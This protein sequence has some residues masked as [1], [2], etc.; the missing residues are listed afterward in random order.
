VNF[1]TL[2]TS[3]NTTVFRIGDGS[4]ASIMELRFSASN[5]LDLLRYLS[6]GGTNTSSGATAI[7]SN[8]WVR[9]TVSYTITNS[10]THTFKVWINGNLE[11]N[12]SGGITLTSVTSTYLT[13]GW[14]SGSG[15]ITQ[16][17]LQHIY[18]DD[19]TTLDDPGDIR[20]T[21]KKPAALN[22]NN[23]DTL[24]GSAT[25]RWDYVSDIPVSDS[26]GIQHA[27]S[28]DVQ[29]NFTL[30][31]ASQGDANLNGATIV[32]R[33]AW[34][35]AKRD[36][37][38]TDTPVSATN[39]GKA[40]GTTLAPLN[41]VTV[42]VG[43]LV[44]VAF[45]D[46]VGGSA[47]TIADN[48]GNTWTPLT[49]GT[50][51]TRLSAWYSRITVAGSMTV[52]VTFGSSSAARAMAVGVFNG[53]TTSPL[54]KNP[55]ALTDSTSPYTSPATGVLTQADEL[56]VTYC[57]LAGP[58]TDNVSFTS[59][60]TDGGRAGTSGGGGASN[61]FIALGY[62]IVTATTSVTRDTTDA[63]NNRAGV[64]GI[65]T[66]K[67]GTPV[68]VGT[69][70]I[71]DNGSESAVTLTTS[72]SLFTLLTTSASYPSNAAG[73]GMRSSAAAPDTF[74]YD[75]GTIIA[76]VPGS[77]PPVAFGQGL[78]LSQALNRGATY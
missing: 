12:V 68:G 76:Y 36:P 47:P 10:T 67:L 46:Q 64:I 37:A 51:T 39:V 69:P 18:V 19:G 78:M 41:P 40:T 2:P 59:P 66:F 45:T 44:V 20:V 52:T 8:T 50:N 55:A 26:N 62:S 7:G 24:I 3:A 60:N 42:L 54:D 11:H 29:E 48:L 17:N 30:Q 43:Q 33:T 28:T 61:C 13:L 71:M 23:F 38:S 32:A 34:I 21:G 4:D 15:G 6:G 53:I 58:N 35:R 16:I 56:L 9:I 73:I 72:T 14:Y 22:T 31:T 74:F 63:T 75:G 70:K 25:N 57:G 27:A 1:N 77:S 49:G 5:K 65:A